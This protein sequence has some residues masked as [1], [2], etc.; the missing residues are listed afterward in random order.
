M[1]G[2]IKMKFSITFKTDDDIKTLC[3]NLRVACRWGGDCC[4]VNL[5][6]CPLRSKKCKKCNKVTADDW[7]R[8]IKVIKEV[9]E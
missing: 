9:K 8:I 6:A 2:S 5:L 1:R 7:A 3:E 4:P